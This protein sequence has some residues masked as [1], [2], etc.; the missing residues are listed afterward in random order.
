M[1][2][3][4][5]DD[6]LVARG[7]EVLRVVLSDAY[8]YD[9]YPCPEP[10]HLSDIENASLG[11]RRI[12]LDIMVSAIGESYLVPKTIELRCA[13]VVPSRRK[14]GLRLV[15]PGGEDSGDDIE[16][17]V[18]RCVHCSKDGGQWT[19]EVER[20]GVLIDLTR[21]P[22]RQVRKRLQELASARCPNAQF[23]RERDHQTVTAF[24]ATPKAR[25]WRT[26]TSGGTVEIQDEAGR[27]FREKVLYYLGNLDAVSRTY[28]AIGR[29]LP[30]PKTQEATAF[31]WKLQ[32][33]EEDHESFQATPEAIRRLEA[34]QVPDD[35][36]LDSWLK[37]LTRDVTDHI[38]NIYGEHRERSLLGKLLVLHSIRQFR[39]D[40]ELL[41]RGWLEMLEVGDTGQGKTQQVD[42]LMLATGM[43]EGVDGVSTSRTGLAYSFQKL[44]DTWFLVWGKYPLNDGKLLFIDE[45]QNLRPDDIDK[46]RK[47]R[48]D[49]VVSAD[50]VRAGEHPSRT[51]LIACCN[52]RYQGVVDDEMFGI[53][54]VKQTFK[55]ED[56]RRFDFAIISSSSDNQADINAGRPAP[57]SSEQRF[58]A[59]S[60]ASS[61][62]WAWSRRADQVRFTD[63]GIEAVYR[64][65]QTL[66]RLYGHARDIPLVLESD[67][68]HKV[69]RMA[70]ALAALVHSTDPSHSTVIVGVEHVD[71]VGDYLVS[72]YDQP[73]CSFNLYA[74]IRREQSSLSE[75]EYE[76]IW[77]ALRATPMEQGAPISEELLA[78]LLRAFIF[79]GGRISRQDLSGEL[80]RTPEWTSKI[81]K[82]LK[83]LKLIRASRGR[84]GGYQATPRFNKFLKIGVERREVET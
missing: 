26:I 74:R 5:I 78:S 34:M 84:A 16:E 72:L 69:A 56:I 17:N 40:G 21:S 49:G 20:P 38:T 37:T 80:G 33:L 83:K 58:S 70:V 18:Q 9:G 77:E 63:A 43:G 52:P 68:R 41:K 23:I 27:P 36:G 62:Q 39:F 45:A 10:V 3:V 51:R 6:L 2:K 59:Q 61:I 11:D 35:V 81:V 22:S 65:A 60:L 66:V 50:G 4:G 82:V 79:H 57:H 28:R 67:A 29:A 47:G 55:D 64:T 25:R 31:L 75:D 53:E 76:E 54:L 32:Q 19:M 30:N 8:P 48:S 73:N 1:A 42:R 12:A 24:L 7:S 44:N 71:A 13:P 46:I 15:Q 14:R